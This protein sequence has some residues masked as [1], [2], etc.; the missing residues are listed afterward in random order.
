MTTPIF[1][2]EHLLDTFAK[3]RAVAE[4]SERLAS[5]RATVAHETQLA[6]LEARVT[7]TAARRDKRRDD[8]RAILAAVDLLTSELP[9]PGTIGYAP[10]KSPELAAYASDLARELRV[11]EHIAERLALRASTIERLREQSA[12]TGVLGRPTMGAPSDVL[13]FAIARNFSV[14]VDGVELHPAA[15]LSFV[16]RASWNAGIATALDVARKRHPSADEFAVALDG[17]ERL[18]VRAVVARL[19]RTDETT[20][21]A[22]IATH[23]TN[24]V[25]RTTDVAILVRWRAALGERGGFR[26]SFVDSAIRDALDARIARLGGARREHE[27]FWTP[28]EVA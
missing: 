21:A 5:E 1:G 19:H 2:S 9:I 6:A 25:N 13:V 8:V 7:A 11:L 27:A 15:P 3:A 22:S 17:D 23:A 10:D 24:L 18:D 28:A 26:S 4:K 12:R 20:P 14:V 16:S